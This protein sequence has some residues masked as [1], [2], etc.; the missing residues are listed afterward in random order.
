MNYKNFIQLGI[1]IDSKNQADKDIKELID[2]LSKNEINLK[3]SND[4]KNTIENLSKTLDVLYG[5]AN[6]SISLDSLVKSAEQSAKVFND[7]GSQIGKLHEKSDLKINTKSNLQEAKEV[8]KI[9]NDNYKASLK[10]AESQKQVNALREKE[11]RLLELKKSQLNRQYGDKIDT[12]YIDQSIN[13]LKSLDNISLKGLKSEISNVK[14]GIREISEQAKQSE[15]I[16]SRFSHSLQ[17]VGI[18]FNGNDIFRFFMNGA[19]NAVNY[20][21]DVE[22]SMINLR[23][24]V[25][26]T[27]ESANN[28]QNN[29]HKLSIDLA[30]SNKDTIETVANFSKLGYS[31]EEASSLGEVTTKFNLAADINDINLATTSLIATLKGFGLE[32]SEAG[33]VTDQINESSNR[34]AVTAKDID[35]ILAKS[36]STLGTF[37]NSLEESIALGTSANEIMQNSDTVGQ[38]L[39][40]IAPRLTTN[41]NALKQ[42]KK[43]NIEIED[44]YGNLKSTYQLFK[45]LGEKWGNLKGQDLAQTSNDLFGKQNIST[46]LAIIK[47][48]EQLDKILKDTKNSA[49]SVQDEFNRYLD[50]TQ[51]KLSQ[52]KENLGGLYS[53]FLNSNMTKGVMDG[54]NGVVTGITS[55]ISKLGS[56]NTI[57]MTVIGSLTMFS[58][59]FRES[60]SSYQP[61]FLDNIKSR[62]VDIKEYNNALKKT[63]TTQKERIKNLRSEGEVT[64]VAQAKLSA[65]QKELALSTVKTV[66]LT[67]R[68]IALQ[69]V[70]SMGLS[71]G[72][73]LVVTGLTKLGSALF[74]T[75]GSMKDCTEQAKLLSDSV[76]QSKSDNNLIEQ[77]EQLKSKIDDT[78]TSEQEK[79]S[80][81]EKIALIKQQL[82]SSESEYAGILSDENLTLDQQIEKMKSL[83]KQKLFDE[84][85]KLDKD[86][87]SQGS[88]EKEARDL[89]ELATKYN[90]LKEA[91]KNGDTRTTTDILGTSNL[92]HAKRDLDEMHNNIISKQNEITK[93][94]NSVRTMGDA[95][96]ST[97]R[98]VITLSDSV[99]LFNKIMSE[100]TS[101]I[102]DNTTAKKNNKELLSGSDNEANAEEEKAQAIARATQEY[103]KSTQEVAK[104]TGWIEKLNKTQTVTPAIARQVAKAYDDVGT[105]VN[106]VGSLTEF[107]NDKIQNQ[108][109]AQQEALMVMKGDDEQ[110][111]QDKIVNN[112]GYEDYLNG[113]LNRFVG[114]SNDNY[115]VDLSNYKT[116]NELKSGSMDELQVAVDDWLSKYIDTSNQNYSIDYSN[117]ENL[118]SAKSEILKQFAGSM[119]QFWD[120]ASGGFTQQAYGGI[121]LSGHDSQEN[122][123]KYTQQAQGILDM[124]NKINS[125]YADLDKIYVGGKGLNLQGAVSGGTSG[126]KFG[127][128]GSSGKGSKGGG[129]NGGKSEVEKY[130]E[131]LENLNAKVDTDRYFELNNALAMVNNSLAENKIQQDGLTDGAL[132]KALNEEIRLM[133]DKKNALSNIV[134]EQKKEI[135]EKR[136]KLE[137]DKFLFD[138]NGQLTNSQ[139]KLAEL[140]YNINNRV[141]ENSEKGVK[142]KKEDIAWLEDLKKT[143]EEYSDLVNSKMPSTVNQ[144]E[145]LAKAIEK[146]H[147]SMIENLRN[148]LANGILEDLKKET[149]ATKEKMESQQEKKLKRIEEEKKAMIEAYDAEI[150]S[151]QDQ[152]KALDDSSEDK[153]KKLEKLKAEKNKW[154]QDD[155]A[156]SKKKQDDLQTEIDALNKD[157]KKDD[158][159]KQIEDL[160]AKKDKESKNYD[161][162]ISDLKKHYDKKKK[163]EEKSNK[164]SLLEQKAYAKADKLLK[165]KNINEIL[166]LLQSKQ[167]Y[168]KNVGSLL[169]ENFSQALTDKIQLS[170]QSLDALMGGQTFATSDGYNYNSISNSGTNYKDINSGIISDRP[171]S[172]EEVDKIFKRTQ[173]F[174]TGGKIKFNGKDEKL[175]FVGDGEKVLT[176][177][178]TVMLDKIYDFSEQCQNV[179][180]DL[181]FIMPT[182]YNNMQLANPPIIDF[183]KIASSM[184]NNTN[185]NSDNSTKSVIWKN[186]ITQN[187]YTKD[188]SYLSAREMDKMLRTQIGQFK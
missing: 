106:D 42:L 77:Y 5:K 109:E 99:D 120:D 62:I 74:S 78:N 53:Q 71:L 145:E 144:F 115:N 127:S 172:P 183:N 51:A 188:D 43:M 50:S 168:F 19:K 46:G 160:Q 16:L 147:K 68:S 57:I 134:A 61:A 125:A 97:Q 87:D 105:S 96:Y 138:A 98:S 94:N 67:A 161:E 126:G 23:R 86:M 72:I 130:A 82:T 163:L 44:Q 22:N 137:Q 185:D 116:L 132:Q 38:A 15:G 179:L 83:Q 129:S 91:I 39:K 2:K 75:K 63:I 17:N 12:S 18:Y 79:K 167:E 36:S 26:M 47:N 158:I 64:T 41:T 4:V 162:E 117:F 21:V 56:I 14:I 58:S 7:L 165:E 149:E 25:D 141:Y 24:V 3:I 173:K 73:G 178:D 54:L 45:E 110:F 186:N 170:L 175:A 70:F 76:G 69:A 80:L 146:S 181:N 182:M 122:Y 35:T 171:L 37:N 34:Y 95:G 113:F 20:I 32:A 28:F 128:G 30:S 155:S 101:K 135:D 153:K 180:E 124:K 139:E 166:E 29:M 88:F 102:N 131:Q 31:L 111:Y 55:V 84:S 142:A 150:K 66:A 65:Y 52:F 81:N 169:G 133:N 174:E 114:N 49:G 108:V 184:I 159:N 156:F 107:L 176:P 60:M 103:N 59:K 152:L 93:Y 48:V 27:D 136:K 6:K 10:E 33:K 154:M 187:I 90:T 123:D 121:D 40:S 104:I 164:D 9:L 140:Q 112:Q 148:D 13:K 100:S 143:T 11:I 177:K 92:E 118:V 89:D 119:A 8:N 1:K 151:L 85:K 157:I